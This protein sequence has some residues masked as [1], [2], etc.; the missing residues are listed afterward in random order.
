MMGRGGMAVF[1]AAALLL[2][3][4]SAWAGEPLPPGLQEKAQGDGWL[5]ADADGM[6][7]YTFD[8]D[9]ATPGKSN[10]TGECAVSWPPMLAKGDAKPQGHWSIITR[11]DGDRQW[12][13]KNFP[14][15]KYALDAFPGA[16]FG[17]GVNSVW[18]VAFRPIPTPGET[19]IGQTVLGQVL[20]DAKGLTLYSTDGACA[21]DCLKTWQPVAAPWLA[22]PFADFTIVTSDSGFRQWAFKGRPLYRYAQDVAPGEIGGVKV[23]G[24]SAVVL[25]PAPPLPPWATVQASDAGELIA[26]E[27]GLTVYAHEFN[28]RNRRGPQNCKD[29]C[30][31]TALWS[32][33]LAAD[34]AK[35]IGSWAI[36]TLPDGRKQWSYKGRKIYT[37]AWDQKPGDFKGIRFGGDRS[38]AA[39]MR[40]G[41]PMQGVTVGG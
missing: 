22:N 38:W 7:L 20:T 10:C 13:Y 24:W 15:Y 23:T 25:E 12:A 16:T 33:F 39:I 8:R 26:N 11:D 31:D 1:G 18:R 36:V 34:D 28:P 3:A 2:A 29:E 37:N 17:N 6:T 27:K 19:K 14:L 41:L 9:E 40:S 21:K 35:P 32:P 4:A 5:F 30:I